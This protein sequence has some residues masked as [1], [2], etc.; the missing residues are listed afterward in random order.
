[1][2]EC[3]IERERGVHEVANA[4]YAGCATGGFLALSGGPTAMATGC[5][6]FAAF[7]AV[8]EKFMGN[9]H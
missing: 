4:I 2:T 5:I 9:Y 6:G 8:I 7:S 3:L 1:M